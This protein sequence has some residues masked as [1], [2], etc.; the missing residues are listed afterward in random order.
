MKVKIYLRAIVHKGKIHLALFDSN[1]HGAVDDLTTYVN[2]GDI[3]I[4]KLD[5]RSGITNINKI[6]P[7]PI[8]D[9]NVK[10]LIFE[11]KPKKH[12]NKE[13]F[14]LHVNSS[15]PFATT[16][17]Y[18]IECNLWDGSTLTFDPYIRVDPI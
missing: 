6:W 2:P 18:N 4:W 10:N 11:C 16:E 8:K 12:L 13:E 15:I 9:K 1:R 3:T 14:R 5:R 17:G 7:K